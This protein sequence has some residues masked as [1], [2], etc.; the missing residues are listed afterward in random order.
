MRVC[1]RLCIIMGIL[2]LVVFFWSA[3]ADVG[4]TYAIRN[5]KIVPVSDPVIDKGIVIIRD[6]LIESLGPMG[7]VAVPDDAEII[8]AEGLVA[9]PGLVSAH[10]NLFLDE[11]K[12][13]EPAPSQPDF[14][15]GVAQPQPVEFAELLAFRLL[16]PKK[17]ALDSYLKIGFTTVLIAPSKGIFQGQSVIVNLNGEKP[18]S[19]ILKNPAALHINLTTGRGTYPSSLMGTIAYIRQSFMDADYYINARALYAKNPK[20]MKRPEFNP[21]LEALG[22]YLKDNKPVVFQ[23][24]NMEDIKRALKIIDEFKL[25]ALLSHA[26]EA[27]RDAAVL[28][29]TPI[30]LLVTLD[31]TPPAGSK[32]VSQGEE[33]KKKAEAEIYPANAANLAKEGI[34]FA[35]TTLGLPDASTALK[36][37]QAAIKAGL[38]KDETLRALTIQPAIYLGVASQ[39]GSLEPGKIANVILTKGE[40]FDEKTVVDKVFVDGLLVKF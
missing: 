22:P 23:C 34:K 2:G 14:M 33:L 30:P 15:M 27:W 5:A 26:N 38:P 16:K 19:M 21:F 10:T 37:I 39:L 1:Q 29:K 4:P 12:T 25:N 28:K 8:E 3:S 17:A 9:Y 24:N 6:G 18:E 36:N 7:K 13:T 40:I 31:F 20:S 32:Y 35:L 11:P